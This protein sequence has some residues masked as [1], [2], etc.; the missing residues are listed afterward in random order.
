MTDSRRLAER[1]IGMIEYLCD[2][3]KEPMESSEDK[4]GQEDLCSNCGMKSMVPEESDLSIR[5]PKAPRELTE[6]ELHQTPTTKEFTH[7]CIRCE[8]GIAVTSTDIGMIKVCQAC[9]AANLIVAP[10]DLVVEVGE[11]D[12]SPP[13][14]PKE[15][16]EAVSE[17]VEPQNTEETT[18]Q[19]TEEP[20]R[21]DA[22]KQTDNVDAE[23][24]TPTNSEPESEPQ[25]SQGKFLHECVKCKAAME[26]SLD[27]VG[28]IE[29]CPS[30]TTANL[31]LPPS[32]DQI[33]QPESAKAESTSDGAASDTEA[34]TPIAEEPPAEEPATPESSNSLESPPNETV[35]ETPA[36]ESTD[37]PPVEE[38]PETPTTFT[39]H[40]IKCQE[41]VELPMSAIG[42]VEVCPACKTANL[43]LGPSEEISEEPGD[44]HEELPAS[45]S[46]PSPEP[47]TSAEQKPTPTAETEPPK[48]ETKS[49]PAEEKEPPA[50]PQA[51]Q[52]EEPKPTQNEDPA[53][54]QT[55][56][57]EKPQTPKKE[58]P[59][60]KNEV[61]P[62]GKKDN[63]APAKEPKQAKP[64]P[65]K[66]NEEEPIEPIGLVE[67]NFGL[68]PPA[69]DFSNPDDVA[70]HASFLYLLKQ[71]MPHLQF[72]NGSP[73][74][75][76]LTGAGSGIV[77]AAA[78]LI[79]MFLFLPRPR[80]QS[81]QAEQPRQ[82]SQDPA[83]QL[84]RQP[85]P[86]TDLLIE[87]W[88]KRTR[89]LPPEFLAVYLKA[90]EILLARQASAKYT[91]VQHPNSVESNIALPA[92]PPAEIV[93][94][95]RGRLTDQLVVDRDVARKVWCNRSTL[96]DSVAGDIQASRIWSQAIADVF[97]QDPDVS[98][99]QNTEPSQDSL[100]ES[101]VTPVPLS[102]SQ[103][104]K[105]GAGSIYALQCIYGSMIDPQTGK[106]FVSP[107]EARQLR[108]AAMGLRFTTE[109]NRVTMVRRAI[110]ILGL[111]RAQKLG[112]TF[113]DINGEPTH[114]WPPPSTQSRA[115]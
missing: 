2:H 49:T 113:Y 23:E 106:R 48:K 64:K 32:D 22:P 39:H 95:L 18:E 99:R 25:Q 29:I 73:I 75:Y 17:D 105:Y 12:N 101:L 30:C 65:A 93:P 57:A 91:Y 72:K 44:A 43:V 98:A 47:E 21:K 104:Q 88:A 67:P 92:P 14:P 78:V 90:S 27:A 69:L 13:E 40:C 77:A 52:E 84:G 55:E 9:R 66:Q 81:I 10:P 61:K 108:D 107:G 37:Q 36:E 50:K 71:H 46:Q 109:D 16:T 42:G 114:T 112:L 6:E 28:G 68:E 53:P 56:Q 62:K 100:P 89:N 94:Y 85:N 70:K 20:P 51:D 34:D 3:C 63:L 45:E 19:S 59:S 115:D 58:K 15:E 79:V 86:M 41:A 26:L 4:I 97:G 103:K 87:H 11:V 5:E 8:Q 7:P 76:I 60:P 31:I 96:A 38:V 24:P 82:D 111:M 1:P 54:N 102:E 33:L 74:G 80:P 110:D 35:E 83:P